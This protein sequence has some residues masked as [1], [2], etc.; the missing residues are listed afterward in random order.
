MKNT[1]I[2]LL[3]SQRLELGPSPYESCD[4]G[5]APHYLCASNSLSI[6]GQFNNDNPLSEVIMDMKAV[7][8]AA[9]SQ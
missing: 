1:S 2:E 5:Q 3:Q 7:W 4:L 9:L 6:N 8:S